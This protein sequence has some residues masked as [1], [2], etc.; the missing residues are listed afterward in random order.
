MSKNR[1]SYSIDGHKLMYHVPRVHRWL[2]GESIYPIYMEISPTGA[3]NHRCTFCALDYMEYQP[4]WLDADVLR[5]RFAE[6][7]DLGLRSL[8]VGG[9]GEPLLHRDCAGIIA[10]ARDAGLDVAL[11]T[12]G[13][14]LDEDRCA[15][16]LPKLEWLKVSINAGSPETY[17]EV[18]RAPLRHFPRVMKNLEAA[19]AFKR[20]D[21]LRCVL[22]AQMLLL[23]EN[24]AEAAPLARKMRALGLDYLVIKPYSHHTRSI[25]QQYKE[26]HYSGEPELARELAELKTDTF[27]VIF[28][29]RTIE[30][31]EQADRPY[32]RCLALPFWSYVDAGGGVWA[33]S[34]HLGDERFRLGD[35]KKQTFQQIWQGPRRREVMEWVHGRMDLSRCRLNCRMDE[36]NRYLW[37]LKNPPPHVNFI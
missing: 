35:L 34:A 2:D 12:N 26:I 25:T 32:D 16:M 27:S 4:R 11:T 9:E 23:P 30:K 22:G 21:G 33:C 36:V 28:R 3:C 13:V 8:L 18:H 17:A 7:G 37:G 10:S 6:L 5:Q 31:W 14:L 15:A 29:A 1:D 20:R 24:R 19:V